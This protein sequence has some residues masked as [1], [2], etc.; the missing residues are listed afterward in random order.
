MNCAA[1]ISWYT[2]APGAE[3]D[4]AEAP[5]APPTD[6]AT[7]PLTTMATTTAVT[8]VVARAVFSRAG[9]N[10]ELQQRVMR[11]NSKEHCTYF[12]LRQIDAL[13][14]DMPW[15][16]KKCITLQPLATPG[17]TALGYPFCMKVLH[18]YCKFVHCNT[19]CQ[20]KKNINL[21]PVTKHRLQQGR[22]RHTHF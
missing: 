18:H 4:A 5:I 7:D 19:I 2:D 6:P 8:T 13:Q 11:N 14:L 17:I 21:C 10:G 1:L 16:Y 9:L 22:Q 20:T 12:I 15:H 3:E